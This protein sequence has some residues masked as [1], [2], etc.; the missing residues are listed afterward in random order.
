MLQLAA[1]EN[2]AVFG[3]LVPVQVP[4]LVMVG[5]PLELEGE[6]GS[7]LEVRLAEGVQS[8]AGGTQV[9]LAGGMS[10]FDGVIHLG[11]MS[12]RVGLYGLPPSRVEPAGV[13]PSRV[14]IAG[15]V[16]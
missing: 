9:G 3:L 2:V 16:Q 5:L 8:L 10:G 6:I 11:A 15:G 7:S 1:S 14:G 4:G 13:I 12:L